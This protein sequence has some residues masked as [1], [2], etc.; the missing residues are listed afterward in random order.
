MGELFALLAA[1]TW[2]LAVICFRK[3]GETISPIPLNLFKN[4]LGIV[5]IVPTMIIL[6]QTFLFPAPPREIFLL[7]ISGA[8][9]IGLSDTMFFKSLNMIG[10]GL[11]AIVDCLYSPFIICL[12]MLI[13]GERLTA[14][15]VVGAILIVSAVFAATF[16]KKN[17]NLSR[18]NLIW[19]I[20]WGVGAMATVALSIVIIKPILGHLPI[21]WSA[22]IRFVGGCLV[23]ALIVLS[24]PNRLRIFE[25]RRFAHGW[26]SM[27]VGSILGS[28]GALIF[29]LAGMKYTQASIAAALNQT[30]ILFVFIFAAVLLKEMINLQRAI[31]ITLGA[32]GVFLV[33]LG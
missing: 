3:S 5:L 1:L 10:A 33:M 13:L 23:L 29:W 32:A 28:Y 17:D 24:R 4:L 14:L 11:S 25:I 8:L 30:S 9:G 7:L 20:F 31:G 21:L 27:L 18:R 22:Q 12:S 26:K 6:G 15:Q 16:E 19:G 2:A